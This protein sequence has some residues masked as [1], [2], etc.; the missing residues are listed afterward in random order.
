M[1]RT[2]TDICD[3]AENQIDDFWCENGAREL[4]WEW[5]GQTVFDI[6][7]PPAPPG[8]S[9][10]EGRLTKTQTTSRPANIWPDVWNAMSKAQKRKAIEAWKVEKPRR[11]AARQKRGIVEISADDKDYL[12]LFSEA[13]AKHSLQK[14]PAMPILGR[15]R[16]DTIG[17]HAASA[18]SSDAKRARAE[19][20]S[21]KGY[22]SDEFFNLVHT[23]VPIPRALKMSDAKAALE[24][25]WKKLEDRKAWDVTKVRPRAEVEAESKASGIPAHFGSLMDLCH[26][27]NSQLGKEFWT[28]KGRIVFRGDIVKDESGQ[29]AVFTEQGASASRMAAAKFMD[30][31]ARMPGNDGQDSDAIGAY[32]QVTLAEASRLLGKDV[33]TTTWISLPPYRRPKAWDNIKDPVCP[34]LLN[35]YG[36]PLAGLLCEKYQESVLLKVGFEKVLYWECLYVHRAKKIFLSA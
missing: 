32:T 33:V 4:S 30:A 28:Y 25:E 36:H 9:W 34:L 20:V 6:L 14:A 5:L 24:K 3:K 31:I 19:H 29:F 15:E 26:I 10:V 1:R 12:R 13:R 16:S 7:R 2:Y 21:P 35:L 8:F 17:P 18:T 27:K 23:H 22:I 11:E